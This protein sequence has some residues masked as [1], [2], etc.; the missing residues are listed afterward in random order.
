MEVGDKFPNYKLQDENGETFDSKQMKGKRY[1]LYFYPKDNTS[2]CTR[3][4]VA[5]SQ[6]LPEFEALGLTVI[7]V[8]KDSVASHRKFV[9]SKELT[10]KLL[11]DPEHKLLEAAGAWGTKMMYGKETT[12]TIRTTFIIGADGK[13]EAVWKKVKVD[14]HI[15]K[16]LEKAKSLL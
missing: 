11:S 7:G 16:V 3:Q 13:V 14:G 9:D 2:G 8:S 15:E 10:I 1:V 5:F 6:S 12:G 4:A